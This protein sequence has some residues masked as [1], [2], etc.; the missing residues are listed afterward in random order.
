[1]TAQKGQESVPWI[2]R[3]D[4]LVIVGATGDLAQRTFR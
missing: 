1:M 4:A 3:V 2:D